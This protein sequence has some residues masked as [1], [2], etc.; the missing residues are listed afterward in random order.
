MSA[1]VMTFLFFLTST[2]PFLK[3]ILGI[4]K[5]SLLSLFFG[6]VTVSLNKDCVFFNA[7]ESNLPCSAKWFILSIFSVSLLFNNKFEFDS[8]LRISLD[9]VYPLKLRPLVLF[10][11]LLCSLPRRYYFKFVYNS[12]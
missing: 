8:A 4:F 11:E 5:T 6:V 2:E 3:N 1:L 12:G 10:L 9:D 7:E